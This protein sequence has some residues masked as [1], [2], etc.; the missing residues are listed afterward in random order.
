MPDISHLYILGYKVYINIPKERQ[1]KSVKLAPYIE[2]GYLI[3]FEGSKI[4]R[5][6][7]PGRAQ[8]I[9]QTSHC[10]FDKSEPLEAP[11]NPNNPENNSTQADRIKYTSQGE[12]SGLDQEYNP[13]STIIVDTEADQ[14]DSDNDPNPVPVSRG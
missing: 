5:I 9:V 14:E 11:E 8:K 4:Y 2:E 1:V 10:I 12:D 6:Y 13:L 3:G 7:L